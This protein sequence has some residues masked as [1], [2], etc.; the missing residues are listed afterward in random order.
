MPRWRKPRRMNRKMKRRNQMVQLPMRL[1]TKSYE[2]VEISVCL[3]EKISALIR[4][5]ELNINYLAGK[6]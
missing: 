5:S 4:K 1:R 3:A 2:C 6:M